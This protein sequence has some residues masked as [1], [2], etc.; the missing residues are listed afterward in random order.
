MLDVIKKI[1]NLIYPE[2]I[3]CICCGS[4]ID[5]SRSYS[6]CDNCIEKLMWIG[7]KTCKKCGKP[8]QEEYLH[9]I[10]RDCREV[11]HYFDKGYTCTQ[12][13]L[14]ERALIMD[15]KYGGRSYLGR[16]IGNIMADRIILEEETWD[17]LIPIPI[18]KKR[19]NKR[20][21]NQAEII[22]YQIAKRLD[23]PVERD[24][25]LR[26]KNTLP[27]KDLGVYARRENLEGAFKIAERNTCK[28]KEKKI[29]LIDDI[30]TT[31]ST[32]DAA[33]KELKL[34]GTGR[35]DALTFATGGNMIKDSES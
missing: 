9:D 14:Y 24:V 28:I 20:G 8:L 30:Y 19:R 15:F 26:K 16:V 3:Y 2:S 1:L 17:A 21:Y 27:M 32:L 25:L 11:K 33:A 5:R 29:L 13:G 18:N 35:V 34:S 22:A 12:Y 7:G 6:I 4:I 10:C 31:G 23:I